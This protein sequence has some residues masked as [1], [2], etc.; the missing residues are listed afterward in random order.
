MMWR[1][2]TLLSCGFVGGWLGWMA[3]ERHPPVKFQTS[4]ILTKPKPGE[5]L[6]IK[7]T[8]WRDKSCDTTVHRIIFDRD[9]DRFIIPDLN[10]AEGVLPLGSDT[11][12]VPIPVSSEA[13]PG[14]AIYRAVHI[15]RCN[16]LH[17]VWP[18]T[19]GPT[20][21]QFTISPR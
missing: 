13:D 2:I 4:E 10:F 8:V 19:V 16:L 20:D 5:F 1:G 3:S 17:W 7:S 9:G 12:V 15:Y 18:I 14:P 11:F 21:M 6:R